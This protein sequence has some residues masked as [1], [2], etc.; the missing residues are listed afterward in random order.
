MYIYMYIYMPIYI[1]IIYIYI[2]GLKRI[3]F[4]YIF[5]RVFFLR[6]IPGLHLPGQDLRLG[7]RGHQHLGGRLRGG[8]RLHLRPVPLFPFGGMIFLIFGLYIAQEDDRH[9]GF[10]KVLRGVE[11]LRGAGRGRV[12]PDQGP[13]K[14]RHKVKPRKPKKRPETLNPP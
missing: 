6:A 3:I 5:F 8:D 12:A 4:R 7:A 14:W 10:V 11:V 9:V 2:I 1:Y 13:N